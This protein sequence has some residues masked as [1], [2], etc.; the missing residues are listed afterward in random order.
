MRRG[1]IYFLIILLI[2]GLSISACNAHTE[3]PPD[4]QAL[5]QS[6]KP[7][8]EQNCARCHQASGAGKPNQYPRLAG[9][10]IVTL[11]D[12]IPVIK[13][14]VYGQGAMPEF[15]DQLDPDQIAEILSYIRNAWGNQAPAVSS[16][17]IP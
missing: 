3:R 11:E 7:L 9:N 12:P 16:R 6:G 1:R 15:G 4:P 5:I 2:A 8:Y 10:P 14:V 13:T 17:Q